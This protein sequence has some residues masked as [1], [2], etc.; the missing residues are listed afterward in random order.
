MRRRSANFD[1]TSCLGDLTPSILKLQIVFR[2]RH[3]LKHCMYLNAVFK[4]QRDMRYEAG[5]NA[6]TVPRREN[7]TTSSLLTIRD[8]RRWL[9]LFIFPGY[10]LPLFPLHFPGKRERIWPRRNGGRPMGMVP[11]SPRGT[12]A[13]GGESGPR[14]KGPSYTCEVPATHVLKSTRSSEHGRSG[15]VARPSRGPVWND[16]SG[17]PN[18]RPPARTDVV[19]VHNFGIEDVLTCAVDGYISRNVF[20]ERPFFFFHYLLSSLVSVCVCVCVSALPWNS[21]KNGSAS[22]EANCPRLMGEPTKTR[23]EVFGERR[24]SDFYTLR[25][26]SNSF[27]IRLPM[28]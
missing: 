15:R 26:G 13:E 4:C 9:V 2:L 19:L 21:S 8:W 18:A 3:V 27:T 20:C 6:E 28:T 11:H 16:D 12:T 17:E 5:I 22:E 1:A 23:V 10:P 14:G 24:R 7:T 25:L